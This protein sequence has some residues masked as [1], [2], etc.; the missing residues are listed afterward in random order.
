MS[1]EQSFWSTERLS[2]GKPDEKGTDGDRAHRSA[3]EHDH[4]RI[5][6]STPVRRLSDKTQVFPLEKNDGVRTRLTHSHE[7]SNL[8]RSIGA[9]IKR[10]NAA[11]FDGQD[12]EKVVAPILG[13]I[14]L[15]HDLGNPP[16]GHQGEAAI[17][18][19]FEQRK[20]WIFDRESDAESSGAIEP[21]TTD[22][23]AEFTSFDGNPQSIRLLTRLQTSFGKVGLDLTA[24]TIAASLKYPVS[25]AN[26][27]KD[28]PIAK[29]FGFFASEADIIHWAWEQTGLSEGQRHPLTWL[30][31]AADDIA[32]SVLDVEDAMKKGIISP[33][34]LINVLQ[35]DG[36]HTVLSDKI[37]ADFQKADQSNRPPSIIRDIKIGYAR[38]HLIANLI[39]HAT[40]AYLAKEAE[41]LAL[42]PILPLMDS[43]ELCD[44]LKGIA[45]EYAFG[46]TEVL[47][48]EAIGRRSVEELM[49]HF[50]TAIHVRKDPTK[51]DSKRSDA[52]SRYVY[53]LISSNYI[54]A[55]TD[56]AQAGSE[57]CAQRLRYRELRLLT[58]MISGMTDSFAMNI[59]KEIA[60]V[61]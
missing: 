27:N 19:W 36:N 28:D 15:A 52:F 9:R 32:Y 21:V 42:T 37:L 17:S 56:L 13:A 61:E 57:G 49:S 47:Q 22:C 26:M 12:F 39:E 40:D 46:N 48:V 20:G 41:I 43:S 2:P 16:F 31:E 29:K 4:D 5:L 50:W 14:G 25:A 58:D 10:R 54:E 55:A 7:V 45:F 24:A 35:A 30:M 53:S 3:F 51:I 1:R 38:S 11:S 6:F 59:A 44:C 33:N 23:K 34:D 60:T 18:R 8:S